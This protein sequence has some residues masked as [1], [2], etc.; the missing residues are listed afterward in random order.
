MVYCPCKYT[1]G[2]GGDTLH[3]SNAGL[4]GPLHPRE[5]CDK[6]R[7]IGSLRFLTNSPI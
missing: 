4:G 7:G 2:S 3:R 1:R 5:H 6:E